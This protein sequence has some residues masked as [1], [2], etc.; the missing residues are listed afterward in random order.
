MTILLNEPFKSQVYARQTLGRTRDED[1]KYIEVV[2]IGFE[3]IRFYYNYKKKIFRKYARSMSEI[4]L[5]D[6]EMN[7]M[8]SNIHKEKQKQLEEQYKNPN[9][10][11]EIQVVEIKK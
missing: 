2:D 3:A 10:G 1:T 4:R 6:F 5:T 8:L 7:N 11:K 9:L